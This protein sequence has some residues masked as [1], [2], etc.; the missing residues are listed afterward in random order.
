[1]FHDNI[2][3]CRIESNQTRTG[4]AGSA[5]SLQ[6]L[7]QGEDAAASGGGGSA[8]SAPVD[9]GVPSEV[10]ASPPLGAGGGSNGKN[11]VCAVD[12][13]TG[14]PAPAASDGGKEPG[15]SAGGGKT[16]VCAVDEP[17]GTPATAA[18]DGGKEPGP[19][20]GGGNNGAGDVPTSVPVGSGEDD[21]H[22]RCGNALVL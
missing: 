1:M 14:T 12:E 6:L 2:A 10:V 7:P 9:G 18:G 17:T 21:A 13:P 16:G 15:P 5:S 19:R 3:F 4:G 22:V 20:A 11:G 8:A